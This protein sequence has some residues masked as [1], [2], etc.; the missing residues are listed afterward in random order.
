MVNNKIV[1]GKKEIGERIEKEI[2]IKQKNSRKQIKHKKK[3][4]KA[5]ELDQKCPSTS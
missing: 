1:L 3:E 2:D 4:K 5:N